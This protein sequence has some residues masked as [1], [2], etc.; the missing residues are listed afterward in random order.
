ML[1]QVLDSI[2]DKSIDSISKGLEGNSKE[3]LKGC[4]YAS[5]EGV[6]EGLTIVGGVVSAVVA[7][8]AIKS[9][10]EKGS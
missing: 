8:S 1:R 7:Y 4:F 3:M 2:D 5:L 6:I 9:I 10:S